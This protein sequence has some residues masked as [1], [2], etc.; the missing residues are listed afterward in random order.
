MR[1]DV[2]LS[3]Q[4]KTIQYILQWYEF[5]NKLSLRRKSEIKALLGVKNFTEHDAEYGRFYGMSEEEFEEFFRELDYSAMLVL[6]AS[7][8]AAIKLDYLNRVDN[9][10]PKG[11]LLKKYRVLYKDKG[12]KASLEKDILEIL[13]VTN[14]ELKDEISNFKGIFKLRHWLAHGRYKKPNLP[15]ELS[16]YQVVDVYDIANNLLG[17]LNIFEA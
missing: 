1:V 14:D 15:R 9:R 8:E 2:S 4:Q 10:K 13:K 16:F 7:A 12:D 3:G 11:D 17:G 5:Q 6:L